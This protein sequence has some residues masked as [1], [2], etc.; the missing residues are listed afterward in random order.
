MNFD[1]K[2]GAGRRR[3]VRHPLS[4]E[5]DLYTAPEFKTQLLGLIGDGARSR[6]RLLVKRS[7]TRRPSACFRR[8]QA[9]PPGRRRLS[10]V[11]TDRNITKISRSPGGTGLPDL[12]L[13]GEALASR[14]RPP[15]P[16]LVARLVSLGSTRRDRFALTACAGERR[17]RR[18]PTWPPQGALPRS[19]GSVMP[20][21]SGREGTIGRIR[22]RLGYARSQDFDES[23]FFEV[24]LGQMAIPVRRS[25]LRRGGPRRFFSGGR[26]IA[27]AA[28]VSQCAALE[29]KDAG[30]PGG[31]GGWGQQAQTVNRSQPNCASCHTLQQR[32]Q[33]ARS[34]ESRREQRTLRARS[35]RLPR[36]QRMPAFAGNLTT[37]RSRPSP[38]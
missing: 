25:R 36:R 28:F 2:T 21:S 15:K 3:R 19:A 11:C 16:D 12:R 27:I 6:R 26:S 37:S 8:R 30:D 14:A 1:I 35:R 22:P 31:R 38:Y 17:T 34:A 33:V 18:E 5:V 29:E 23:T 32:A 24:T 4:G 13:A 9:S 20:C 10:I 7:S